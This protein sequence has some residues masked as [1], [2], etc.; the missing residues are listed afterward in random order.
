MKRSRFTE[1]SAVMTL[2]ALLAVLLG[3]APASAVT[4]IEAKYQ[5]LGGAGGT[6]GAA[7]SDER[8]GL[9][10]G[11]CYKDFQRGQIHWTP[12]TGAM[13]TYCAIGVR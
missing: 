11:G 8:C 13:A 2:L 10:A 1:F 4:P 7:M 6:L 5:V 3:T 9:P 12:A